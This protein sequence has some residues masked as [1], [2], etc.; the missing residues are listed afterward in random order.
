MPTT[1]LD[2]FDG[3]ATPP[4]TPPKK[5]RHPY[6][7]GASFTIRDHTPPT[8]LKDMDQ[9]KEIQFIT[10]QPCLKQLDWV[11]QHPL[12]DTETPARHEQACN[13]AGVIRTG[14]NCGA[15]IVVTDSG[16]VAKIFDPL[17]YDFYDSDSAC[18]KIDICAQAKDEYMSEVAAYR[19]FE[20]STN[21]GT[22]MP[23]YFG[24]WIFTVVHQAC[25]TRVSR[26]VCMV[27]IERIQGISMLHIDPG[28]LN[29]EEKENIMYKLIEAEA[30]LRTAGISHHD[31]A[32]RNVILSECSSL[33]DPGLRL[34]IIDCASSTISRFHWGQRTGKSYHNP[35]WQW[36]GASQ[37]SAWGWLPS[38]ER[39]REEWLFAKWGNGCEEKYARLERDFEGNIDY[40]MEDSDS[41]SDHFSA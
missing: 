26:N 19:E 15:Q 39:D 1:I 32:P 38:S 41:D 37:W 22:V 29:T 5:P 13:I 11:L 6:H 25:D 20:G 17:Y 18:Q 10:S 27:L 36:R 21:Q 34:T 16:L 28:Y 4:G 14:E 30:T 23:M 3:L 35:F 8:P 31:L 33:A 40:A 7:V 24:S 2:Q 9:Q 12:P